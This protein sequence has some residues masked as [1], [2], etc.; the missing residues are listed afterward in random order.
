M[1]IKCLVIKSAIF[2]TFTELAIALLMFFSIFMYYDTKLRIL[3][4]IFV[5]LPVSVIFTVIFFFICQEPT[6]YELQPMQ[7]EEKEE[8]LPLSLP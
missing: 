1:S 8:D 5:S 7:H 4:S 3:S 6:S 2:F